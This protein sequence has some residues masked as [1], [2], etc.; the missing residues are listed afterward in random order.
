M[1][2]IVKLL[3]EFKIVVPMI[4]RDYAYGREKEKAKREGLLDS[5]FDVSRI[6]MYY[7]SVI[8]VTS[9]KK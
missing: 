7:F 2:N 3:K 1:Y 9:K 6:G 4:Q 8:S 5:I